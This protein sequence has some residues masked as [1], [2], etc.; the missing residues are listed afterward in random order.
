MR[1]LNIADS[2]TICQPPRRTFVHFP[3]TTPASLTES[4]SDVFAY[5][6][7]CRQ[8][9]MKYFAIVTLQLY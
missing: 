1:F 5:Q 8:M 7:I 2:F 4:G 9:N 3:T 6:V